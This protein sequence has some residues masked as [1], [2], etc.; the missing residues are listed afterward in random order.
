MP[1]VIDP[2][3]SM[4][5]TDHAPTE[6][7]LVIL[8]IIDR[9]GIQI[10]E[11]EL[12]RQMARRKIECAGLLERMMDL[13]ERGLIESTLCFRVTQE[14]L[15]QLPDGHERPRIAGCRSAWRCRE[16]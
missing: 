16:D 6:E 9:G 8:A 2:T 15:E 14:G 5:V 4:T 7:E 3:P 1:E 12:R 13:E 11:H 10:T